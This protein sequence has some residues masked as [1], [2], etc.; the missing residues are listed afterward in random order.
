MTS[1]ELKARVGADGV[2]ALKV[3]VGLAEADR[4]VC[5]TV[6]PAEQAPASHDLASWRRFIDEKAGAWNGEALERPPQ[7][8][9]E[10]REP[11]T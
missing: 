9:Y 4:E 10:A 2:L 3:P 8:E 5:V 6:R 1:I 7:G 11:W